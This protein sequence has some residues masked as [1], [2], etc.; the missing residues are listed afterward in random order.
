MAASQDPGANPG[1]SVFTDIAGRAFIR[2]PLIVAGA[3]LVCC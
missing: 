1:R 2:L 3:L